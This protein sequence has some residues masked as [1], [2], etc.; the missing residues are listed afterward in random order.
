LQTSGIVWNG[1]HKGTHKEI[2]MA[3]N[4]FDRKLEITDEEY[5]RRLFE[6]VSSDTP[7]TPLSQHPISREEIK[8]N[9]ERLV[10]YLSRLTL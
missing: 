8:R 6:I 5:I 7:V 9:E 1:T 10:Q 3:T 2:H 4:T